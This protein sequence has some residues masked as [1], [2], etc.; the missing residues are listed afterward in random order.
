MLILLIKREVLR[1]RLN[2][3]ER[4]VAFVCTMMSGY[5]GVGAGN[6]AKPTRVDFS[7][8]SP[9]NTTLLFICTQVWSERPRTSGRSQEIRMSF[10]KESRLC[11][12]A[13]RVSC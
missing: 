3:S 11:L 1:T 2:E 5:G 10:S 6:N 12:H 9:T 7:G 4:S 13:G 8:I